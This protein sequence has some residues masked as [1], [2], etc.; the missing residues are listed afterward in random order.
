MLYLHN[1]PLANF[2]QG[3]LSGRVLFCLYCMKLRPT[4]T[5]YMAFHWEFIHFCKAQAFLKAKMETLGKNRFWLCHCP[6]LQPNGPPYLCIKVDVPTKEKSNYNFYQPLQGLGIVADYPSSSWYFFSVMLV[7]QNKD[8]WERHTESLARICK[9][10]VG[11][12]TLSRDKQ[13]CTTNSGHGVTPG[14]SAVQ[15]SAEKNTQSGLNN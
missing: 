8:K 12:R 2:V 7:S 13:L 1:P 6:L 3:G 9:T 11:K 15:P 5:L 10:S 4:L 14:S